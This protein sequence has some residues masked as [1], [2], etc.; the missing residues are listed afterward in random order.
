MFVQVSSKRRKR[1]GSK[2]S[3][4]KHKEIKREVDGVAIPQRN[5]A[6]PLK[7]VIQGSKTVA[8]ALVAALG[9]P[10]K[11]ANPPPAQSP[12]SQTGEETQRASL[13]DESRSVSEHSS[14]PPSSTRTPA[15]G[16]SREEDAPLNDPA[17]AVKKPRLTSGGEDTDTEKH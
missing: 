8:A 10:T 13:N 1:S 4:Q 11:I 3:N 14:N 12:A 6:L 9:S 17:V 7:N 15:H 2:K 5:K 16:N